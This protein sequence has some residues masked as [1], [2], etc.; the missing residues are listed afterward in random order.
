MFISILR[1]SFCSF[2]WSLMACN[3][4][5]LLFIHTVLLGLTEITEQWGRQER[6]T[7]FKCHQRELSSLFFFV[8]IKNKRALKPAGELSQWRDSWHIRSINQFD[9]MEAV[10]KVISAN[11]KKWVSDWC[12]SSLPSS[13]FRSCINENSEVLRTRCGSVLTHHASKGKRSSSELLHRGY[14]SPLLDA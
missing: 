12:R 1:P 10:S 8:V 14:A 5:H 2:L 7:H 4:F 9:K 6:T 3:Y 11:V 13:C